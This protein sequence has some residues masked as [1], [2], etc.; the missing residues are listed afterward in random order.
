MEGILLIR[1]GMGLFVVGLGL[2]N[3]LMEYL[4]MLGQSVSNLCCK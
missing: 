2:C 1:R 3:A 4:G